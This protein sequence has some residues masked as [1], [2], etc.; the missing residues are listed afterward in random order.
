[1]CAKAEASDELTFRAIVSSVSTRLQIEIV[2]LFVNICEAT[3]KRRT[4]DVP[5]NVH[6]RHD[7]DE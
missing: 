6:A 1:M 2:S 3:S 7:A 5:Q 4:D